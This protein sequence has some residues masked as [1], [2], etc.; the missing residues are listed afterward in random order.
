[1][2]A[3]IRRR[4]TIEQRMRV[5]LS[6][7]QFQPFYQP[8]IDLK[9]GNPIGFELLARW[10]SSEPDVVGPDEFIPIAEESGFINDMMLGL[11]ERACREARD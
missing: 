2:D 4:A 1:M 7:D 6:N 10:I 11:I 3:G 8:I 5:A 9:S